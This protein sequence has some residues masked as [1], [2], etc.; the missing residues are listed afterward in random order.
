MLR[1]H[2]RLRKFWIACLLAVFIFSGFAGFDSGNPHLY[3]QQSTQDL[4]D[5]LDSCRFNAF[6][7]RDDLIIGAVILNLETGT[8]CTQNLNTTFPFAS[9]GKLFIAG[10][11]YR[12]VVNGRMSFDQ[13]M[14]FMADY[15]MDGRDACLDV[16]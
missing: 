2:L 10:A 11:F 4:L 13:T 1:A 6:T 16:E 15:L 3:A 5:S 8:G 14:E 7:E 9:V 12:E